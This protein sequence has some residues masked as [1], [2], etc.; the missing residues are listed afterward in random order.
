MYLQISLSQFPLLLQEN[1]GYNKSN[2]KVSRTARMKCVNLCENLRKVP[3]TQNAM[4][5]NQ[6]LLALWTFYFTQ[7]VILSD[8][9]CWH[10]GSRHGFMWH[11]ILQEVTHLISP[12]V[13]SYHSQSVI[14]LALKLSEKLK[15]L[16]GNKITSSSFYISLSSMHPWSQLLFTDR[17]WNT[18]IY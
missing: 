4:Y 1:K 18:R 16:W 2:N 12:L 10:R 13:V 8:Y 17:F 14:S 9:F 5:Q 15:I 3:G 11:C 7:S 6:S